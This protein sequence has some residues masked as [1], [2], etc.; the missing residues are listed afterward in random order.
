M[1]LE[2]IIDEIIAEHGPLTAAQIT[3]VLAERNALPPYWTVLDVADFC[4]EWFE[5]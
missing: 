3:E 2:Q 1:P 5:R 4:K